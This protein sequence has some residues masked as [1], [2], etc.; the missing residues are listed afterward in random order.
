MTEL[1]RNGFSNGVFKSW[2]YRAC[3]KYIPTRPL[4]GRIAVSDTD[5]ILSFWNSILHPHGQLY[6]QGRANT[7]SCRVAAN[8]RTMLHLASTHED[9]Y[10]RSLPIQFRVGIPI[11]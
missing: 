5:I 9:T 10:R 1:G 2:R 7:I 6:S 3:S 11:S 8:K 4:Q